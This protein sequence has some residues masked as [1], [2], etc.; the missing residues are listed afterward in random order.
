MSYYDFDARKSRG[1]GFPPSVAQID[2]GLRAHMQRVYGYMAGGLAVTGLV[3]YAAAASGFYQ[4][5]AGTPLI[6]IV[7]LAPLG[8]VLVLSFGIERMSAGT[9]G[10]VCGVS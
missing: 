7:M 6:W 2:A 3:A 8:F 9:A 10:I 1:A 5:I 4:S